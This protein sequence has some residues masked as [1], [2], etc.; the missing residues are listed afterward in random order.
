M[1]AKDYLRLAEVLDTY[2]HTDEVINMIIFDLIKAE[3]E[4][5]EK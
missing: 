2:G 4:D 3:A 5:E 1:T